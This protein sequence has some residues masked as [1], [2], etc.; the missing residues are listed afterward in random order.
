[1]PQ[2]LLAERQMNAIWR[3]RGGQNHSLTKRIGGAAKIH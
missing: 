1:M 2:L 3:S